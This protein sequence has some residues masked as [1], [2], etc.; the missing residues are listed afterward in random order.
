VAVTPEVEPSGSPTKRQ[1]AAAERRA[2]I[3][4]ASRKVFLARGLVGARTR[5][6]A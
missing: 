3:L 2:Q 5:Q 4:A 1:L 6:I